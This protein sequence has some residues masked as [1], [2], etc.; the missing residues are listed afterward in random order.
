MVQ[1]N[2]PAGPVYV[3]LYTHIFNRYNQSGGKTR[4]E[5]GGHERISGRACRE[6]L[7]GGNDVMKKVG[8]ISLVTFVEITLGRDTQGIPHQT[9]DA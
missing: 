4:L 8:R 9:K 7:E 6:G 2:H 1:Q 5:S 3:Y